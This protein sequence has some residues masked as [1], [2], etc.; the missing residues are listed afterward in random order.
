MFD[1]RLSSTRQDAWL[2]SLVWLGETKGGGF[3]RRVHFMLSSAASLYRPVVISGSKPVLCQIFTASLDGIIE[4]FSKKGREP[5]A[6]TQ[7]ALEITSAT[8]EAKSRL[9]G[10]D[11]PPRGDRLPQPVS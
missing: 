9:P 7:K 2:V 10:L 6:N 11:A 8:Q 3:A 4:M 5:S 1:T